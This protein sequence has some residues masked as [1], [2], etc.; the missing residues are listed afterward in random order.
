MSARGRGLRLAHLYPRRMNLYGDRGNILCLVRRCRERDIEV[1]VTQLDRGDGLDPKAHDLIFI[2]GAQDQDQRRIADDLRSTK[3]EAL[4]EAVEAGAAVLAVCGGYQLF[5]RFY[6]EASG[7]ELEGLGL[8]DL[9]TEH[10]GPDAERLIGNVVADWEGETLVGFEN[11]GGR[12]F[13]GADA[14]PLAHVRSG[15]GNN[16]RDKTEG[17]RYKNAFGTYL[18]GSLL[19]KNPRFADRLIELALAHRYGDDEPLSPI[20]DTLEER[21]HQAALRLVGGRR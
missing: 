15:H 1:E 2:G 13:L 6:R 5:G 3:G 12:T 4:R 7:A 14:E 9:W 21:A 17:V 19:P 10:P 16:D 11:H 8:F 18:H 20:D